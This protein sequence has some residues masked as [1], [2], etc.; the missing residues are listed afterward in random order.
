MLTCV[1]AAVN[2][3]CGKTVRQQDALDA[4]AHQVQ[5]EKSDRSLQEMLQSSFNQTIS[6]LRGAKSMQKFELPV[7]H[8][9]VQWAQLQESLRGH[10]GKIV[11][12]ITER[13]ANIKDGFKEQ[14]RKAMG[15]RRRPE[16]LVF[17]PINSSAQPLSKPSESS[18]YGFP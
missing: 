2:M 3:S 14:R 12:A 18:S 7:L 6:Q 1:L 9:A 15:L 10:K 16:R 11:S 13:W 17:V 8:A 5:L 4:D